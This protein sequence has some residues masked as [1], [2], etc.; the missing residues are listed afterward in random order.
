[1][2][3]TLLGVMLVG[4]QASR[5]AEST[6]RR[7][8]PYPGWHGLVAAMII[9]TVALIVVASRPGRQS[10][11]GFVVGYL[12]LAAMLQHGARRQRTNG[13][14]PRPMDRV[15]PRADDLDTPDE[16]VLPQPPG[17]PWAPHRNAPDLH[18]KRPDVN[19]RTG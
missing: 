11:V 3:W 8:E 4:G 15:T 13:A 1:M 14:P 17:S 7:P 5:G 19:R 6:E 18:L 9:L 2:M 10:M 16:L 12:V